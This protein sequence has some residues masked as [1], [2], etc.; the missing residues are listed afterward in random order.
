VYAWGVGEFKYA[1]YNFKT[2]KRVAMTTTFRQN[3]AKLHRFQ[4]CT[5]YGDNFYVYDRVYGVVEFKYTI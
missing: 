2:G 1:N 3:K 5:R 4:F